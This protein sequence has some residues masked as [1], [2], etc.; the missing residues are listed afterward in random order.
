MILQACQSQMG[1][2]F[3]LPT[4]CRKFSLFVGNHFIHCNNLMSLIIHFLIKLIKGFISNLYFLTFLLE[5]MTFISINYNKI[6]KIFLNFLYYY[7]KRLDRL[8]L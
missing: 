4:H 1:K 6:E 8:S 3:L 7:S 5:Y 2:K